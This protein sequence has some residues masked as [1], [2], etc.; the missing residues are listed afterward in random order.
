MKLCKDCKHSQKMLF[1]GHVCAVE[2]AT[3][4][5]DYYSGECSYRLCQDMREKGYCS[6]EARLFEAKE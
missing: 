1:I 2:A 4:S 3:L 5:V 6:K